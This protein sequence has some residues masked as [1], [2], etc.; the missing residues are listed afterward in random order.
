MAVVQRQADGSF[1]LLENHCPICAAA[2]ACTGLC[3]QEL[4]VFQAV[5][6]TG[7]AGVP[8]SFLGVLGF[9]LSD[10]S[11]GS[12][13]TA[14]AAILIAGGGLAGGALGVRGYRAVYRYGIERGK[15][16]LEGLLGALAGHAEGG[17][18]ITP[19]GDG[20][21]PPALPGASDPA[22]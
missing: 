15:K 6:A 3:S 17:W 1:L 16:A 4:D 14:L 12:G 11:E 22:D 18:R 10:V 9:G 21:P 20:G 5:L 2:V 8:A 13:L 19:L 7:F